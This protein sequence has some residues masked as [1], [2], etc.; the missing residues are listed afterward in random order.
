MNI[1]L[2]VL[3]GG[4]GTRLRSVV[5]NVP[6]P[7]APVNNKPFL[8]YLVD[9]WLEQG[10]HKFIFL[11]HYQG[12]LIEAFL[13]DLKLHSRFES[14]EFI[15]IYEPKPLGTGGAIKHALQK[16]AIQDDFFVANADTWLGQGIE[17]LNGSSSGTI[18]SV[19]V[20]DVT[21]YGR[22]ELQRDVV[23]QFGEK[24]LSGGRGWINAGLYRLNY[25]FF[26][27]TDTSFSLE[28]KVL[29]PAAECQL[30]KAIKVGGDFIDIGI[31]EDYHRF[32][33]WVENKKMSAL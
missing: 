30:L 33:R 27:D 4:F 3:A 12:D 8:Y 20:S 29:K 19:H 17:A 26:V 16:L 25:D 18:A 32:C 11:L 28:E 7:L 1:P 31:P 5:N 21:R 9:N 2:F 24:D 15:Y 10:I 14:C 22:L 13:N 23:M 6:K